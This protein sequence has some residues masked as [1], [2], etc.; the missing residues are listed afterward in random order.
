MMLL[1]TCLPFSEEPSFIPSLLHLIED[2]H[3]LKLGVAEAPVAVGVEP[4]E[5]LLDLLLRQVLRELWGMNL[6]IFG[7][8]LKQLSFLRYL[9]PAI[10]S[11]RSYLSLLQLRLGD[12]AVL[13]LVVQLEHQLGLL[14]F[15]WGRFTWGRFSWGRFGWGRFS[16]G[17]FSWGLFS[18]GLLS[19]RQ[20]IEKFARC[21]H[22]PLL[23]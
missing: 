11:N 5:D 12:V 6:S 3:L 9:V 7:S 21:L 14:L 17:R 13:V 4:G 20:F 10:K 16:W 1:R 22:F 15:K 18:W 23:I 8:D 2:D 19:F